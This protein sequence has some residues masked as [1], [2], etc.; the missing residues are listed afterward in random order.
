MSTTFD[1][2]HFI[3]SHLVWIAAALVAVVAFY[4][5]RGEHDARLQ[6][7][8]QEKASA[9]VIAQNAKDI[10]NLRQQITDNDA[11]A[12]QKVADIQK[13]VAGRGIKFLFTSFEQFLAEVGTKPSPHLL[14]DRIKN[15]GHYEPGNVRWT[16]PSKS[17]K[18]KR[19]TSARVSH[20]TTIS[21]L[22][23]DVARK[24]GQA[25]TI[26]HIRWHVNRGI[27]KED[28][29]QCQ[30]QQWSIQKAA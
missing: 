9:Q 11:K 27:V 28:C 21:T 17:N 25:A 16:T 19:L 14:L 2:K 7:E 22:G 5:W 20:L 15:D 26:A 24:S 6:A 3:L 12:A 1:W 13:L 8:A 30:L 23:A 18:N 4:Q 29:T 10:A